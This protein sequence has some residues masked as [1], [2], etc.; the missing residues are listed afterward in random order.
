MVNYSKLIK[1]IQSLKKF[2][3]REI[4][5]EIGVTESYLEKVEQWEVKPTEEQ[6][7][8]ILY[9]VDGRIT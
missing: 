3:I 6:T 9:Y 7:E 5:K 8:L 2:T 1:R 4:A